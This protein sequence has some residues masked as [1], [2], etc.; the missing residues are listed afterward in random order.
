MLRLKTEQTG[1][2]T[3]KNIGSGLVNRGIYGN[4]IR[5]VLS[6]NATGHYMSLVSAYSP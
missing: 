6:Y 2:V 3:I 5:E 1:I 4:K